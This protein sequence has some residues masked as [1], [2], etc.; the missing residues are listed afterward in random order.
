ME[1]VTGIIERVIHRNGSGFIIFAVRDGHKVFPVTG[2]DQD[3]H[4]ADFVECEGDWGEYKGAPQFKAK[5]IIPQIPSTTEAIIAYLASGRIKGISTVFAN[6]LVKAFGKDVLHIIENEPHRLKEV[7]GFGTKRI[8]D[9]T[10][11]LKE[12]IGYRSILLFLHSF[13][14]SKHHIKRIYEFH[15]VSAVE[16]IKEDPYQLCQQ[17][18]GIGF[19]TADS[20]GLQM[21]IDPEHPSR[22][23]A[24]IMHA[25]NA[26]VNKTGNTGMP[27]SD[28][29]QKARSLLSSQRS[30]SEEKVI[31]GIAAVTEKGEAVRF[32]VGDLEYIFPQHLHEAERGIALHLKRL[33]SIQSVADADEEAL[34]ELIDEVQKDFGLVLGDKQRTAVKMSLLSPVA[35]ITGGPGTGK[36]T[37]MRVFLECCRRVLGLE[38]LDI[39]ACAPTGKAAKRLSQASGLEALTMHRALKYNPVEGEFEYSSENPLPEAVIVIDESS[40]VDTQLCYWMIQA[41][42]TGARLIILGD[43]DQLASVGPGKVLADMIVSGVIPVT[44]LNEIRRQA[45]GSKI[46]TNAHKINNGQMPDLDNSDKNGDFWF[47]KGEKDEEIANT[48]ISLVGRMSKYYNLDP[49]DDIQIL[50]PQRMGVLGVYELN[51]RLQKL[52]NGKNIG[53]GIKLKQ[54]NVDVEFCIGDKVMHIKNN[55]DLGVFNGETGRVIH[56]DKKSRIL[57]VAYDDKNVEYAFAELEE[58]RLC[59]AM[60]IHKSQGS[61]YRLVLMPCTT[62]HRNMLNRSLYYTGITRA[63]QLMGLVGMVKALQVA[64]N[65]TSSDK[66]LTGLL[67]HLT[68]QIP[69]IAA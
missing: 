38:N 30:V 58:L 33:L 26:E 44:R 3:L 29:A 18:S 60:T 23:A 19:G 10:E 32:E 35:I 51:T 6:R 45:A 56:A 43:V 25:L 15:G 37:I 48:I 5:T 63:K 39:L 7:Q 64:V 8:R 34:N 66:R 57:K 40:M 13:G 36:T 27:E 42:A 61:E 14:L 4:E 68:N 1:K 31:L 20:I 50:T 24:G 22:I 21:G 49:F 54:D 65:T 2:E 12:Q 69:K 9:L 17:I 55:R 47:F 52:L 67:Q 53:T 62:S 11:G 46:I 16:R 59:Y 28:L 41:V